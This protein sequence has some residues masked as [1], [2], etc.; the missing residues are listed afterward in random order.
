MLNGPNLLGSCGRGPMHV[1]IR[2]NGVQYRRSLIFGK[3]SRAAG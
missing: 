2:K 3:S 1:L